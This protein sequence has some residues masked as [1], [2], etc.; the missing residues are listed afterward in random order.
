MGK[1]SFKIFTNI[2]NFYSRYH[3]LPEVVMKIYREEGI[4]TLYRGFTP[5]ILGSIPYSGTS[6]F[7]YESLKKLHV[8]KLEHFIFN[9][10]FSN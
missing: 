9:I 10:S 6:F 2:S 3:N 8:G 1:D 7:T 5:T 4:R